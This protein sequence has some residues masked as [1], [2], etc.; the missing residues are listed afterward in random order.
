[1]NLVFLTDH[2]KFSGG[3]RLMFDYASYLIEKGHN[4]KILVNEERGELAGTVPVTVIPEFTRE[5]IPDCDLIIATS[6]KEVRQAWDCSRGKVVHFCQGFELTDLEHRLNGKVLPPRFQGKGFFHALKI[7]RKKFTWR[8]KYKEFDE[9]YKLPTYLISVSAHLQKELEERYKRPAPLCRN[10]VDLNM[11]YPNPDWKPET[12]SEKRPIRIINIGPIEV[13]YKG[14]QTTLEAVEKARKKGIPIELTR[15]SPITCKSEQ[16]RELPY[17]LHEKL[18]RDTFC[19]LM[20]E[21]DVYISNS[22][23][24]EGFGL[25]AMEA[26]ASGLVCV[27]SNILC[28]RSF[29]PR[30][31]HC[32]FVPEWDADATVEAIEKIYRMSPEELTRYRKNA[33]EVASDFSHQK[34]CAEFEDILRKISEEKT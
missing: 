20:R 9:V 1:M 30:K 27:F 28:Y 18:P 19:K 13:T 7:F 25:P 5:Y 12:F 29:S 3:R 34:A 14:I 21:S 11:F 22:T 32:F 31:D 26:L 23:E 10:G 4:V 33:L 16:G 2:M 15:I 8:R 6:P 24:R 17:K